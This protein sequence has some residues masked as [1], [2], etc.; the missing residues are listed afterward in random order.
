MYKLE[1]EL[2]QNKKM[3]GEDLAT[4]IPQYVLVRYLLTSD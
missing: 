4:F 1:K 3:I 2:I